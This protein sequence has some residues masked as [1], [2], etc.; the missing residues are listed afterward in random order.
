VD[1]FSRKIVGGQVFDTESAQRASDLLQDICARQGYRQ[2][3]RKEK[4]R[5]NYKKPFH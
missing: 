4:S 2:S 1:L 5:S 3:V